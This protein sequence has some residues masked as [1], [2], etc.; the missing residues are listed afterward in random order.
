MKKCLLALLLSL[1]LWGASTEIPDETSIKLL[2]PDFSK[3]TTKR[4]IL[5][6]KLRVYLV[7]DPGLH[8]SGAALVVN[9]GSW[10]EPVDHPGLAHFTEHMLFMGT[11]KFPDESEYESYLA[12][13]GGLYNAFTADDITAYLFAIPTDYFPGALDRF[14]EFFKEPL[15]ASSSVSREVNAI[16]QEYAG[17]L[18]S[19]DFREYYILKSLGSPSHP[20]SRFGMGNKESL[21]NTTREEMIAWYNTHYSS[22]LMYLILYS[23]LPMEKL[24]ALVEENFSSIPQKN[25]SPATIFGKAIDDEIKGKMISIRPVK[26]L[27]RLSISWELPEKFLHLQDTHPETLISSVLGD[28]GE[29]SLLA[30][31][32]EENLAEGIGVGTQQLGNSGM[33]FTIQIDLT[34][35]GLE[36]PYTVLQYVFEELSLLKHE[37]IPEYLFK[38]IQQLQVLK[39]EL[40]SR[41]DLFEELM[42]LSMI[43][44]LEPLNTFPEKSFVLKSYN[45]NDVKELLSLLTPENGIYT[46]MI[47]RY[48]NSEMKREKWLGGNYTIEA[49]PSSLLK[50]WDSETP[51]T[52]LQLPAKN[53]YI[54]T[55]LTV[56]P[57]PQSDFPIP[58]RILD[59][60]FSQIYFAQDP[61]YKIPKMTME[62]VLHT[63]K[64]SLKNPRSIALADMYVKA[65]TEKLNSLSYP[66]LMAGLSFKITRMDDTLH[67]SLDG[68]NEK[69][70]SFM[71]GVVDALSHLS[72]TEEQ[73]QHYQNET[74]R[75]YLNAT[76][77]DPLKQASEIF[78]SLVYANYPS[79][80]QKLQAVEKLTLKQ[81]KLFATHL[82]ND[83][84]VEGMIYGNLT[85]SQVKEVSENIYD[86][87]GHRPYP[88]AD[89]TKPSVISLQGQKEPLIVS[90]NITVD[91]N[92]TFLA[93]DSGTLTPKSRAVQQILERAIGEPF[94]DELRTKQQ[95]GYAV[96]T[97][98]VNLEKQL[99]TVFAVQSNTHTP[100]DLLARFELFIENFLQHLP[101]GELSKE[102]FEKIRQSFIQ[103]LKQPPKNYAEMGDLLEHLAF[104]YDDDFEWIQKR[105]K[106]FEE[107]TFEEFLTQAEQILGK[108]N[109]GRLAIL[110]TGTQETDQ[111]INY[112]TV[113]NLKFLQGR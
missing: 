5:E 44:P 74:Q 31:L 81:L 49:I 30:L 13:H 66:A 39:Y 78:K 2:S 99:F 86:T 103:E 69:A 56:L 90:R 38:D 95:T 19:D 33:L 87:L 18:N 22:D 54:P 70:L 96:F 17:N 106:A 16:N 111:I 83:L 23:P 101:E 67:L 48:A 93:I 9:V 109:K 73:F 50:K 42:D 15:F 4:L 41:R 75:T 88:V 46:R 8:K 24:T 45:P 40:Q 32:K 65:A 89:Q 104:V 61:I 6:N 28:E 7:S 100:R 1:N 85:E 51:D 77:E 64:I 84:Y 43:V 53:P 97:S 36:A 62:Y 35:K 25:T 34:D 71:D 27:Q 79:S 47:P 12:T 29:G 94:F 21:K 55:D 57:V 113:K 3:R 91:G 76:K 26:D 20:F 60:D 59:N 10:N 108:G 92:A 14:S 105:I 98:A 80:L 82:F 102:K 112:R 72:L 11:K 37:G 68:F 107:L 58:Q 52:R 63:P 110:L